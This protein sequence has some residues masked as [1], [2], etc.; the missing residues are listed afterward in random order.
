MD[1]EPEDAIFAAGCYI[2]IVPADAEAGGSFT[3]M[4]NWLRS[5]TG[6]LRRVAMRCAR[7][8]FILRRSEVHGAPGF[9]VTWFVEA[10][11]ATS[12]L[13][14]LRRAE[15]LDRALRIVMEVAPASPLSPKRGTLQ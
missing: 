5:L 2:D 4:D 3:V 11:G 7:T 13:A 6:Q 1:A 10:C 12:E 8:D 9:A 15:A 14:G